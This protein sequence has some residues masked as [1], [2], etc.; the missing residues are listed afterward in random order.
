MKL[1]L[2]F[3]VMLVLKSFLFVNAQEAVK[4][5]K[6]GTGKPIIFI[7]GLGCSGDVWNVVVEKLSRNYECHVVNI[8]GFAGWHTQTVFNISHIE[9]EIESYI[10]NHNMA[11]PL[12]I[13]HSLGGFISLDLASKNS[14]LFSKIVI[15]DSYP[16]ALG[17]NVQG[18]TEEQARQQAEQIKN[19][20]LQ[21]NEE[22]YKSQQYAILQSAISDSAHLNI[23]LN[24]I[25]DSDRASI[26]QAMYEVLSTDL[27]SKI[28]AI[29]KPLLV[30]GTWIGQK[31]LGRTKEMTY[32]LF[33]D[34]YRNVNNI[35]I[36]VSDNSKHFIMY[37]DPDWLISN[38]KEYLKK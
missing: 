19:I 7:P 3:I 32:N 36:K 31:Q 26:A 16:F 1:K 17:A 38:I 35:E 2:I 24:W 37:D 28:A 14:A 4:I 29:D 27:R 22:S 8:A 25:L 30:L 12:L 21:M 10:R 20:Y 23:V 9:K 34:Q 33:Q 18:I 6:Q 13:G 15:I 5:E 11:S